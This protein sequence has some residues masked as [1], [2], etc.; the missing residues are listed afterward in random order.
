MYE[1]EKKKLSKR[2]MQREKGK[3]IKTFTHDANFRLYR[4]SPVTMSLARRNFGL[5]IKNYEMR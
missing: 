1:T 3:I 4:Y 2:K 5:L